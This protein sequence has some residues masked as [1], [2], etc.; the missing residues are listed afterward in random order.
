MLT[1]LNPLRVRRPHPLH[2]VLADPEYLHN[3]ATSAQ[4]AQFPV[5]RVN[6]E[7]FGTFPKR[8]SSVAGE[9][10]RR[11]GSIR[12]ATTCLLNLHRQTFLVHDLDKRHGAGYFRHQPIKP[13]V[14]ARRLGSS[15][16]EDHY[17]GL[18]NLA[19]LH[20]QSH[21]RRLNTGP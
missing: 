18:L 20:H 12:F 21:G 3:A 9:H 19:V 8:H 7:I 5:D 4:L 1:P 14:H 17:I 6:L 15:V 10:R 2:F 16:R 13:S 11:C